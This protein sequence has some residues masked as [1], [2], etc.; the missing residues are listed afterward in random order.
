MGSWVA[1]CS[2][3][4][5][6]CRGLL[7]RRRSSC[8]SVSILVGIRLSISIRRGLMSWWVARPSFMTNMFS[9]SRV[10]AA[11]RS[12]G[13]FIGIIHHILSVEDT[14]AQVSV[15][16]VGQDGNNLLVLMVLGVAYG[17]VHRGPGGYPGEHALRPA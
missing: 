9:F 6:T 14:R 17:R 12:S 10:K 5:S 4:M 16:A 13:T 1:V 2:S 8:V 11:G 3:S 7:L 15:A